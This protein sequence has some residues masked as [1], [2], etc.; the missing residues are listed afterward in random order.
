MKLKSGVLQPVSSFILNY[1]ENYKHWCLISDYIGFYSKHWSLT[2]LLLLS[3]IWYKRTMSVSDVSSGYLKTLPQHQPLLLSGTFGCPSLFMC[4]LILL[5]LLA[6]LIFLVRLFS[7]HNFMMCRKFFVTSI[8]FQ[9]FC[10]SKKGRKQK[11]LQTD[12]KKGKTTQ[13]RGEIKVG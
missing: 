5:L 6:F 10:Y 8:S 2:C 11:L 7:K 4:S 3:G 12:S 1:R 9:I 13:I